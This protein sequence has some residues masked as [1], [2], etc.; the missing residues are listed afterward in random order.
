MKHAL[1]V[2]DDDVWRVKL[3]KTTE[4][5]VTVDYTTVKIVQIARCKSTTIK[6]NERTKVRWNNW[7]YVQDHPLWLVVA[8]LERRKNTKTLSEL[9]L[10]SLRGYLF[11]LLAELS[12]ERINIDSLEKCEDRLSTHASLESSS[13]L[14]TS[15]AIFTLSKKLPLLEVSFSSIN[16][17]VSLEVQNLLKVTERKIKDVSDTAWKRLQEPYVRYWA[18]K[19]DVPHT[20]TAYLRLNNLYTALLAHNATVTKS[21]VLTADTLV[22]LNRSKNLSAEEAIALG[23]ERSIVNRLWLR[24]LAKR[25]ATDLVWASQ[26]DLQR[27]ELD[28]VLRSFKQTK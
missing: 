23:L 22:I 7:N 16:Y 21:L 11:D 10:L 5:V 20:L 19:L 8:L 28:R 4:T 25:P 6:W 18:R 17:N 24:Y 3:D 14:F 12:T 13:E 2:S 15:S 27:V 26:R 1:L 9:L